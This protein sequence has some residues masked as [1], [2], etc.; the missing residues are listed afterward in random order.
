MAHHPCNTKQADDT[1][2]K[3]GAQGEP[4]VNW[5][6][7]GALQAGLSDVQV[8]SSKF[9]DNKATTVG[10]KCWSMTF[11]VVLFVGV[12]PLHCCIA[13]LMTVGAVRPGEMQQMGTG[14]P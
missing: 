11:G 1:S 13:R 9:T 10:G 2:A 12:W 3:F 7:G 14:M 8:D 5:G 4:W 6:S